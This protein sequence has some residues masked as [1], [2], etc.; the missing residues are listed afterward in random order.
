MDGYIKSSTLVNTAKDT[1]G[2]G[3]GV[4]NDIAATELGQL[5]ILPSSFTGSPRYMHERTQDA[6]TYLRNYGRP[7]LFITFT[8]NAK[9]NE[10]QAELFPGQLYTDIRPNCKS[11]SSQGFQ[12]DGTYN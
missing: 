11:F 3:C 12:I 4:N 7:D 1:Q 6:M 10:I 9:W 5:C 8:C 2:P